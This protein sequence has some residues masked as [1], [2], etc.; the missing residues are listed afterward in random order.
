MR[1]ALLTV[2]SI[3]V[4]TAVRAQSGGWTVSIGIDADDLLRAA[5]AKSTSVTATPKAPPKLTPSPLL[6]TVPD[7]LYVSGK[8]GIGVTS[9]VEK[10]HVAGG[11]VTVRASAVSA[12][13]ISPFIGFGPTSA[14]SRTNAYLAAQY[15]NPNWYTSADLLFFTTS[16]SDITA[17]DATEKMR[18]TGGGRV[19]IGSTN[20]STKF[21]VAGS[22][23]LNGIYAG[24][25][26][27]VSLGNSDNG[28]QIHFGGASSSFDLL[29][30]SFGPSG[31][32]GIGTTLTS[33]LLTVGPSGGTGTKVVVNGDINVTGNINAKYQDVAEWVPASTAM[34][35][36]SVVVLN[37]NRPNEVMLSHSAYDI[38][39]AGVVSAQPGLLLGVPSA[40]KQMI[41]TTGRAKVRVDASNAPIRIGDLLVTS[42]RPGTAMRSD[43]IEVAGVKMHRPGTL[44]GKALEP[45]TKGEGKI[46]VLLSLQ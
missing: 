35:P 38:A 41:A 40:S 46:L 17:V 21:Q 34:E 19:G 44:I 26:D 24:Y 16:A 14:Y 10:L 1:K 29:L 27:A 45:L 22:S 2:L 25:N 42:D 33:A 15:A 7:D 11:S 23:L 30:E 28:Q 4:S 13:T 37:P 36:G 39:V 43:P 31:N 6:Y 12:G 20:P 3:L 18:I 8:T 9:P 5:A 32:V